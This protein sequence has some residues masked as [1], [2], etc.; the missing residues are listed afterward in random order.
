M[1]FPIL[2]FHVHSTLKPYGHS[3]YPNENAKNA[4]SEGCIWYNDPPSLGDK[5]IENTVGFPRFRQSD[6]TSLMKGGV[7]VA[8]VSLYPIEASFVKPH[9][10]PFLSTFLVDLISLF[11]RYRIENIKKPDFNYFK[12][13]Q[14]EYAFLKSL[15]NTIPANGTRKYK[16]ISSG[17]ELA[18][19]TP[20]DSLLIITSIEGAHV[21]CEGNDVEREDNWANLP[22]NVERVKKWEHPP[23]FITLNH[24]FYNDLSSHAMSLYDPVAKL[25]DQK[26]KMDQPVTAD[27]K[28]I[29]TRGYQV[30]DLLYA[31][32]NGQRILI[33]IK[34]MAKETRKEFYAYHKA[35]YGNVPIICSHTGVS[36]YYNQKINMD[37]DDIKEIYESNGMIGIELDQRIL[38][39]NENV[40]RFSS[41]FRNIFRSS[42]KTDYVWAE[43]F[44]KN[45]LF[46][47][48]QCYSYNKTENP[49][50]MI[51]LGSDLDGV[52]NPLNKF[53]TAADFQNLANALLQYVQEYWGSAN[54]TIPKNHLG[55][56]AHDVVY[57]IMY[58][59]ALEFIKRNYSQVARP[60]VIV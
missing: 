33:D 32:T 31:T 47:A 21:F 10:V 16:L 46:I 53:R 14:D 11:G 8:V 52:I 35:K 58:S 20:S 39:Y 3:F 38:G 48:E 24:H 34:H 57:Q 9:V 15:D 45:I 27:G 60:E 54:S 41:W 50:R 1:S 12:D 28:Y 29:T 49:W 4:S 40:N 36:K 55:M 56:D 25:I 44:W 22:A 43:Y 5:I 37:A 59:N 18:T 17:V 13:L 23:F 2:D 19:A 30:I 42:K 26:Y 6:F 7:N 51:C